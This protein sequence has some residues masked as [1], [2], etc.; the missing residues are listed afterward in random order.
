MRPH[1]IIEGVPSQP[2][3]L[4]T[5]RRLRHFDSLSWSALSVMVRGDLPNPNPD[6]PQLDPVA[7]AYW[8][9]SSGLMV[10]RSRGFASLSGGGVVVCPSPDQLALAV[11]KHISHDM[12][13]ERKTVRRGGREWE[14][15]GP[16]VHPVATAGL[17]RTLSPLCW[18]EPIPHFEMGESVLP[19]VRFHWA[20]GRIDAPL[21]G[22][23]SEPYP[24]KRGF[25]D[26][27]RLLRYRGLDL[28]ES[29]PHTIE[30]LVA[31][32][33]R[34]RD[35]VRSQS[36]W[37]L[38]SS[39]AETPM[40]R[41]V[42]WGTVAGS[43]TA[44]V[45]NQVVVCPEAHESYAFAHIGGYAG[46]TRPELSQ[47]ALH[48]DAGWCVADLAS[49]YPTAAVTM[50]VHRWAGFRRVDGGELA[51]ILS[52]GMQAGVCLAVHGSAEG[53]P[54][55]VGPEDETHCIV[56]ADMVGEYSSM[57]M[58]GDWLLADT[59]PQVIHG[60]VPVMVD[61][62]AAVD[63]PYLHL[64]TMK[65]G[66]VDSHWWRGIANSSYGV[67]ARRSGVD[68]MV[69]GRTMRMPLAASITDWVRYW[70]RRIVR[71]CEGVYMDTDCAIIPYEQW[72]RAVAISSEGGFELKDKS[73]VPSGFAV[74]VLGVG[75][76]RYALIGIDGDFVGRC[77]GLG[78]WWLRD[79]GGELAPVAWTEDALHALWAAVYPDELGD[80]SEEWVVKPLIQ[81]FTVKTLD[82]QTRLERFLVQHQGVSASD[83]MALCALGT[84][85][86]FVRTMDGGCWY[87][88][89]ADESFSL[90]DMTLF[91]LANLWGSRLDLKWDYESC[92]RWSFSG[93]DLIMGRPYRRDEDMGDPSIMDVDI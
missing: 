84:E 51:E 33:R 31:R 43:I 35:E 56:I 65:R 74:T 58:L 24:L 3:G 21:L 14:V 70:T 30:G 41:F 68:R 39:G 18:A 54:L 55:R 23:E 80:P 42:S 22:A 10:W 47:D 17:L 81:R 88:F 13:P 77:H 9:P 19:A 85:G 20:D 57:M 37:W 44:P 60:W 92:S 46:F 78:Q 5:S 71:E 36:R 69:G 49:A 86:Y 52:G 2:E 48:S 45:I 38:D 90:S 11:K 79:A 64:L 53:I 66:G 73:E 1:V 34:I 62:G 89:D 93:D 50:G 72:D 7:V 8:S 32:C 75:A 83:A 26:L 63:D 6:L 40:D 76:K 12:R 29:R 25:F 59:P 91:D 27:N 16:L 28:I 4:V 87:S 67:T 61:D 82:F 15:A